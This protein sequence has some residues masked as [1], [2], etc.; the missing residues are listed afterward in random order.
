MTNL[1][2]I[3]KRIEVGARV[4]TE[5][6][7]LHKVAEHLLE[8]SG[9]LYKTYKDEEAALLRRLAEDFRNRAVMMDKLYEE[10]H[11]KGVI[12]GWQEIRILEESSADP[13]GLGRAGMVDADADSRS[14]PTGYGGD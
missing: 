12:N 3:V 9:K 7:C 5:T 8:E 1:R 6:A 4:E 2:K 11:R 10:T 13:S 14:V